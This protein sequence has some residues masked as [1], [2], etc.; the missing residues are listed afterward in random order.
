[1]NLYRSVRRPV[2]IYDNYNTDYRGKFPVVIYRRSYDF[3]PS[4]SEGMVARVPGYR[5]RGPGLIPGAA[6]F[7]EK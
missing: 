6:K 2:Y 1:M 4:F 7:S 3:N 5:S